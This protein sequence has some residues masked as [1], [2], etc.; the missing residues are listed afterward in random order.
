MAFEDARLERSHCWQKQR[1]G[2]LEQA[3]SCVK[4]PVKWWRKVLLSDE[5]TFAINDHAGAKQST[6]P[7]GPSLT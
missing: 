5:L 7:G 3:H 4:R 1:K 6:R 2:R